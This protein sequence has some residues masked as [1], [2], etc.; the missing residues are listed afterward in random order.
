MTKRPF[1]LGQKVQVTYPLAAPMDLRRRIG[2]VVAY[3]GGD[4]QR[5][6]VYFPRS[7]YELL[8]DGNGNADRAIAGKYR[9]HCW[10]CDPLE[11]KAV[12]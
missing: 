5:P 12:V 6:L 7:S 8:H 9:G 1:K 10:Y 11:L 4:H 3:L 2:Y